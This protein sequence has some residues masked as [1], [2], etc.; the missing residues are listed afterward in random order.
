M[1]VC[2]SK[3]DETSILV[4]HL[5]RLGN[6]PRVCHYRDRRSDQY[7]LGF[8]GVIRSTRACFGTFDRFLFAGINECT[9]CIGDYA[10]KGGYKESDTLRQATSE[11][12]IATPDVFGPLHLSDIH[13]KFGTFVLVFC[14]R[15]RDISESCTHTVKF[16]KLKDCR[17]EESLKSHFSCFSTF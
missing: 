14:C 12:V 8:V 17:D 6:V 7:S 3:A 13:G 2:I 15:A 10:V 11:P 16:K 9:R 1:Q 5:T 4:F